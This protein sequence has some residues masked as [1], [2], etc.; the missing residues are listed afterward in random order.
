M[1]TAATADRQTWRVDQADNKEC[2]ETIRQQLD[3]YSLV[4][5]L[6]KAPRLDC[7]LFIDK[8]KLMRNLNG[9]KEIFV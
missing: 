3:R 7:T 9:K 2:R 1:H 4:N 8:T 5:E 6:I